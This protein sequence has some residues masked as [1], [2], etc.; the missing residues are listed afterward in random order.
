MRKE[1]ENNVVNGSNDEVAKQVDQLIK[2]NEADA[3]KNKKLKR[4]VAGKN[5]TILAL[6]VVIII[7]LLRSCS[8]QGVS[9]PLVPE[10]KTPVLERSEYIKNETE[11]VVVPRID[12]PLVYD[13]VV[14]EKAPYV[15][16]YNPKTNADKYYLQYAF[17]LVEGDELIYES[18]LV[19]PE[20]KFS[21]DFASLLQEGEHEAYVKIKTYKISDLS[22]CN[23]VTNNLTITVE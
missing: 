15:T 17:Y 14:S 12:I 5:I 19:E 6:I 2:D 4:K 8:G 22:E 21:V 1:E 7:L 3:K 10:T 9:N 16:L 23:G 13:I 20:Y 18:N 11:A